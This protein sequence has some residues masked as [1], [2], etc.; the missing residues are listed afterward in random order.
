MAAGALT[1]R[2]PIKSRCRRG[3]LRRRNYRGR[4]RQF[5]RKRHQSHGSKV[6]C[7]ARSSRGWIGESG[8]NDYEQTQI[9]A[10]A[11]PASG[12][13]PSWP[14]IT[15]PIII[16][17]FHL[18][19]RSNRDVESGCMSDKPKHFPRKPR[20]SNLRRRCFA[21]MNGQRFRNATGERVDAVISKHFGFPLLDVD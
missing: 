17:S 20:P 2:V 14:T 21:E 4:G 5:P 8:G 15:C 7:I 9:I 16:G 11:I 12:G 10:K 18:K 6:V 1:S 13:R 3:S 19:R